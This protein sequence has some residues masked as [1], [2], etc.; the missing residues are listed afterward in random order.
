MYMG[1]GVLPYAMVRGKPMFL[2]GKEQATN[3]TPGWADFGGG[4]EGKETDRAIALREWYE[5]TSGVFGSF[6]KYK[7]LFER[8]L[9]RTFTNASR[10]YTVFLVRVPYDPSLATHY[11]RV[12]DFF[13]RSALDTRATKGLFEKARM[14]WFD[15]AD[16][17]RRKG[18]FRTYYQ[19]LVGM[20]VDW[21]E[22]KRRTRKNRMRSSRVRRT[23]RRK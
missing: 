21:A 10:Q 6:A 7:R 19:E 9:V 4:A 1:A 18:Q 15:V 17:R 11:N 8:G 12:S 13:E 22:R 23:N 16:M 3:D 2:F 14:E 20:V 5:E